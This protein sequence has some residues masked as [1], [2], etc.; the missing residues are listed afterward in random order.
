MKKIAVTL[1]EPKIKNQTYFFTEKSEEEDIIDTIERILEIDPKPEVFAFKSELDYLQ[2]AVEEGCA[3]AYTL[4]FPNDDKTPVVE[5]ATIHV[6]HRISV[7]TG[8]M[9]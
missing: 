3:E 2:H 1:E 8:K 5:I 7:P 4:R 9:N 6:V